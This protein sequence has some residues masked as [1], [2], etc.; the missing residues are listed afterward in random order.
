MSLED[1]IGA[2][3]TRLLAETKTV[4]AED[5]QELSTQGIDTLSEITALLAEAGIRA[6]MGEDVSIIT[7]A[8]VAALGNLESVAMVKAADKADAIAASVKK[9]LLVALEI[10]FVGA[11]AALKVAIA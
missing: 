9:G 7:N 3:G 1:Q 5:W 4:L 2:V 6:Q 10:V 8:C 11:G